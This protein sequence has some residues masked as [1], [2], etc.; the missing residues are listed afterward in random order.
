MSGFREADGHLEAGTDSDA[1]TD[2]GV[3]WVAVAPHWTYSSA[4]AIPQMNIAPDDPTAA[5]YLPLFTL[6]APSLVKQPA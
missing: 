1:G 4:R 2:F 6:N 3:G 5:L